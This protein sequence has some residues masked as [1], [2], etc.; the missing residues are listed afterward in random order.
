M[1][2]SRVKAV[3]VMRGKPRARKMKKGSLNTRPRYKGRKM[4]KHGKAAGK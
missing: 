2:R 4:L 3:G 1:A